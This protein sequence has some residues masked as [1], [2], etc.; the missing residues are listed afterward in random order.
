ML[1]GTLCSSYLAAMSDTKPRKIKRVIPRVI[2]FRP[3]AQDEAIM[4]ELMH[5][6]GANNAA[7][8]IRWAVRVA[9]PL[10]PPTYPERVRPLPDPFGRGGRGGV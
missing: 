5:R 10:A 7:A 8:V 3:N 4:I 2:N 6:I 9:V 1:T